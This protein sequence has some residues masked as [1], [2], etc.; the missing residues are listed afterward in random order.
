M[1]SGDSKIKHWTEQ[2]LR[3]LTECQLKKKKTINKHI[4]TLTSLRKTNMILLS[5]PQIHMLRPMILTDLTLEDDSFSWSNYFVV[6]AS[7]LMTGSSQQT[8]CPGNMYYYAIK[9]H[10]ENFS[11]KNLGWWFPA[12][13]ANSPEFIKTAHPLW[14]KH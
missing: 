2:M 3:S 13:D 11:C 1:P 6:R 8:K 9:W 10:L 12:A 4:L 14:Q 5:E 7:R